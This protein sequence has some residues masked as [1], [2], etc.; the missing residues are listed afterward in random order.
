MKLKLISTLKGVR[1]AWS[2]RDPVHSK[3]YRGSICLHCGANAALELEVKKRF[4]NPVVVKEA[5]I[6]FHCV[7]VR[8]RQVQPCGFSEKAEYPHWM[9]SPYHQPTRKELEEM[10]FQNLSG[11]SS[12]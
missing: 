12:S 9:H 8:K 4:D 1:T 5:H 6:H 7:G 10:I 3:K 11:G 2:S